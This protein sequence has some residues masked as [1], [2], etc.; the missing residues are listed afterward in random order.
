[1]EEIGKEMGDTRESREF[2]RLAYRE[3]ISKSQTSKKNSR[4]NPPLERALPATR[5]GNTV[6]TEGAKHQGLYNSQVHNRIC[7]IRNKVR[8]GH[9]PK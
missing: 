5:R 1:M 9:D 8:N 4:A 7:P 2:P 6:E 3:K